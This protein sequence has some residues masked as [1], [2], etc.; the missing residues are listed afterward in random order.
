MKGDIFMSEKIFNIVPDAVNTAAK[1]LTDLPTKNIGTTI[2]DCWYLI[3][4]GLSHRAD[5]R[6]IKYAVELKKFEKELETSIATVPEENKQEPT[7]QIIMSALDAAKYCVEEEELRKLFVNLI[8][9]SIDC[10]KNVHPSFSHIIRQMNQIDAKVLKFFVH[11]STLPAC[12]LLLNL[13]SGSFK[14]LNRNI[15]LSIDN[16]VSEEDATASISSLMYLG[17]LE[18]PTDLCYS[19]KEI[20]KDFEYSNQYISACQL[21]DKS[22]LELLN[23][24]IQLTPLGE[25]F[26]SCCVTD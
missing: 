25:S 2:A 12:D 14:F 3:F 5:K 9:S 11:T 1:N 19:N 22:Q 8:T 4:G 17:L 20:Y 23:K 26:V 21:H 6:K 18:S 15:F 7:T 24:V 10:S 16:D 13:N